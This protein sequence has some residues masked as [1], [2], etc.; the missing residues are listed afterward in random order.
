MIAG[1]EAFPRSE[2]VLKAV[3]SGKMRIRLKSFSIITIIIS[4]S[5]VILV[6]SIF[7]I[8][9]SSNVVMKYGSRI[10][11]LIS[12]FLYMILRRVKVRSAHVLWSIAF[13]AVCVLNVLFAENRAPA[14]DV[15][16]TALQAIWIGFFFVYWISDS[17]GYSF[18]F[19]AVL[20]CSFL[21][22]VRI[23]QYLPTIRWGLRKVS[24]MLGTNV[25]SIGFRLAI[26]CLIALYG[27]YRSKRKSR[28]FYLLLSLV[29]TA[30]ILITGSRRAFLLIILAYALFPLAM[31]KDLNRRLKALLGITALIIA[32]FTLI[33][34]YPPLYSIIGRRLLNALSAVF[35]SKPVMDT[36]RDAMIRRGLG[37]FLERPF[38]GWG[39]GN[40]RYVS[41]IDHVYSHNN[42]VELLFAAGFPGF[43]AYYCW[44]PLAIC[45]VRSLP[46]RTAEYALCVIMILYSLIA[47]FFAPNYSSL[48]NH[49]LFLIPYSALIARDQGQ[50]L[51]DALGCLLR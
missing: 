15:M 41:G 51:E 32:I 4:L 46:K 12:A 16:I 34:N 30:F 6:M 23:L 49:L 28:Y 19:H 7:L 45:G 24:Y 42:Y 9:E 20:L 31:S 44:L 47:D 39:M 14:L 21:Y 11:F 8:P 22:C 25:N 33:V 35:N 10:L 36:G 40:F 5:V 13:S 17:R 50:P 2:S 1:R 26:A 27:Y 38:W 29:Y 43:A 37:L 18:F 48:L 3:V